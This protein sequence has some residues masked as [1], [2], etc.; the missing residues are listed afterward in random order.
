MMRLRA[1]MMVGVAVGVEG[2]SGFGE[3]VSRGKGLSDGTR[4]SLQSAT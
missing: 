4:R 1:V 2:Q 3:W